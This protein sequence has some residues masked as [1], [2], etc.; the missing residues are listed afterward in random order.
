MF[1]EKISPKQS[2][3]RGTF[4]HSGDDFGYSVTLGFPP[5]EIPPPNPPSAFTLD[6]VFKRECIWAGPFLRPASVLIDRDGPVVRRRVTREW[7]VLAQ[8]VSLYES[9]FSYLGKD[10]H[11]PEVFEVRE[12]IR[13]WRF[14]DHFRTDIDAPTRRPQLGTRTPIMHHDGRDLA[15]ALQTIREIGDSEALNAAIEDAF[16]G[17]VLKIDAEAGGLFT[18]TLQQEGLLRPLTAAELSD[19]TLRYLLL[20]AASRNVIRGKGKCRA[21]NEFF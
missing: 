6:P 19:G 11:S 1:H 12:T 14:Y 10:R 13:S 16:P 20:I 5:P 4:H 3:L 9:L 8:Q 17:S 21:L 2:V 15:A 18:L 7:E